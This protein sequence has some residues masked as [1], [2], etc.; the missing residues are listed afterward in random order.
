[1]DP[2]RARIENLLRQGKI[3]PEEA[4]KLLRALE[5]PGETTSDAVTGSTPVPPPA[6]PKPQP[7]TQPVPVPPPPP[8]P[9]AA[10]PPP[11]P[12]TPPAPP[13]PVPP[14]AP[15]AVTSTKLEG[16]FT[17]LFLNVNAGDIDVRGVPGDTLEA[18]VQNGTLEV[19]NTGG[20]VRITAHGRID[21]PTEIGW[22]NT[23]IKTIG[24]AL[25]V[26]LQISVPET[27]KDLE[28]NALAGDV[29]VRGVKGH[30]K[31]DLK[32]GDL[33]LEDAAS[34]DIDGKAGNIR[35]RTKLENG[36]SK[37]NAI[38]GNVSIT[39]DS[40]SSVALKAGISAGDVSAKGFILTQSEKRVVGGS[41]EGRLGAGRASLECK[42]A[43]GDLDIVAIDGDKQ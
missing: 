18:T 32:A 16:P 31:L 26:Q 2:F 39:L 7:Q 3:T 27:L 36:N 6:A 28:I 21:D 30:V 20:N 11:K 1:M 43:A 13:P 33:K 35:I 34:F 10:P 19:T 4:N 42:L 5:T 17:G 8:A 29:D 40:G 15:A 23:V 22:L 25:P 14:A 38:A 41:L 12:V 37:V 9:V 24:R